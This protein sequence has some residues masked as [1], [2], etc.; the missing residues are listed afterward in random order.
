MFAFELLA[1]VGLRLPELATAAC[2]LMAG[3]CEMGR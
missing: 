1:R 3:S 2:G